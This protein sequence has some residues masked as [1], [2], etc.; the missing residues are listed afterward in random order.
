MLIDWHC[1]Q[2][3]NAESACLNLAYFCRSIA[4]AIHKRREVPCSLSFDA[5]EGKVHLSRFGENV[6]QFV[7]LPKQ[8]GICYRSLS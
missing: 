4:L 7:V 6:A 1:N 2:H 8:I 5:L 3:K